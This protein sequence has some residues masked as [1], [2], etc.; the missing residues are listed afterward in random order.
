MTFDQNGIIY[1][2]LLQ[3]EKIFPM[4]PRSESSAWW[5][6][7][8]AQKC[9]KSWVTNSELLHG[10]NFPSRWRFLRS[11]LTASKPSR[12]PIT[13]AKRKEKEKK[14]RRKEN[15]K[16][17]KAFRR[18]LL[19]CPWKMPNILGFSFHSCSLNQTKRV[20]ASAGNRTRVNC[21]EGSYAHHYTTDAL[22]RG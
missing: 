15:F 18:R 8:Y 10:Q 12:R 3:E 9:S 21:L 13:A 4:M 20:I 7:R 22:M 5:S 11:F 17:R 16:N 2:Q 6:L 19:S 14:E 1:S